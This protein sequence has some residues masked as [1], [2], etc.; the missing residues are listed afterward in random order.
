MNRQNF[1]EILLLL[2]SKENEYLSNSFSYLRMPLGLRPND[3]ILDNIKMF[4][5]I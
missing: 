5:K 3:K 2:H 4:I 1:S